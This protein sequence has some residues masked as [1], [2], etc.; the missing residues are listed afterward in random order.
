L[1]NSETETCVYVTSHPHQII[2]VTVIHIPSHTTA[3]TISTFA[4]RYIYIYN[5][6]LLL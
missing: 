3:T 2:Y 6:I 1:T 5:F 4:T